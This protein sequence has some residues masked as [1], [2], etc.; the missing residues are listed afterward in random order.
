MGRRRLKPTGEKVF[1]HVMTRTAQG[2][3]WLEEPEVKEIF[4]EIVDFYTQVYYVTDL[5]R[6]CMSNHTHL[7]LEVNRPEFDTEDIRRRYELAQTRI[8]KQRPFREDRAEHFYKRYTDLSWFMWEINRQM[9]VRYNQLKQTK[10]HLW[11]ARFKNV[12]VE[13]G[14]N[15]LRVI[16]YVET[17]S[18]RAKLVDDPSDFPYS[19]V[20]RVKIQH[21][22]GLKPKVPQIP[23]FE[24]LPQEIRAPIYVDFMRYVAIAQ[25]EPEL[26]RQ[27]MPIKFTSIGIEVNLSGLCEALENKEPGRWSN[28]IYGSK[29]FAENTLIGVG[30]LVP[31]KGPKKEGQKAPNQAA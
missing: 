27:Q 10:G 1:H 31:L 11:G 24:Q 28:L 17:N 6:T 22:Q 15:L 30:W 9:A 5:A 8:V 12:V 3:F 29:E 13:P 21:E 16:A 14:E 4:N 20:G 18:V 2:I 25:A 26:R 23:L 19:S 7:V